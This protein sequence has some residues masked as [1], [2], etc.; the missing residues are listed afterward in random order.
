MISDAEVVL[1]LLVSVLLGGM[2]G[3]ERQHRR[4]S[5]GLGTY[6]LVCLGSCLVTTLSINLYAG[7]QGLTNAD[8]ARLAAQVVSGIGF[9]GAGAILKEGFTIRGLT[10]AAGLWV[11]ACVGIAVGAGAMVG[12]ITTTGLVVLILVVKPRVEKMLFGYPATMSLIIHAEERPGQIGLIGSYLG[13]RGCAIT[14]I[15]I[16]TIGPGLVE[17]P[18]TFTVPD[19]DMQAG[20]VADLSKA[21]E[22][23][24]SITKE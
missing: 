23:L 9:L 2:V 5:A 16:E 15:H 13:K 19:K 4:K 12:A 3:F 20:I 11:S 7:V 22:G 8:P 21:V 10:T 6:M 1:R 24:I 18:I 14:D 17:I